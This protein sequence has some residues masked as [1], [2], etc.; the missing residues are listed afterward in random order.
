[1][2]YIEVITLTLKCVMRKDGHGNKDDLPMIVCL[3]LE[4]DNPLIA[5]GNESSRGV[6]LMKD[7]LNCFSRVSMDLESP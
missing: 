1:M 5:S 2:C 6:R 7:I 4:L 3:I